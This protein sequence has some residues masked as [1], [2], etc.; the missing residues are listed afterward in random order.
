MDRQCKR[1]QKQCSSGSG[2]TRHLPRCK[3]RDPNWTCRRQARLDEDQVEG[4]DYERQRDEVDVIGDGL[5][6]GEGR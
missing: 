2:L 4:P 1:C 6:E 3:G 5:R